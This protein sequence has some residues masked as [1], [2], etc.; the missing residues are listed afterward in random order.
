M[1]KT[2]VMAFVFAAVAGLLVAGSAFAQS[3]NP[4]F[5]GDRGPKDGSGLL[6]DYISEAMADALGMSVEEL[7][8]SHDAGEYFND[9]ALAS[10]LSEDEVS[11][12]MLEARTSAL[13]AAAKD[14]VIT[15][16]QAE[17]MKERGA[18]RGGF[19]SGTCDGRGL[20]GGAGMGQ[21]GGQN[22]GGRWQNSAQ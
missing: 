8:A 1:K 22:Q 6:H 20:K 11:A 2:L 16:E 4:P 19:G 13:D 17:W 15:Q 21:G 5:A 7:Q 3:D 12:L 18:G 14:G 10:G 9:L